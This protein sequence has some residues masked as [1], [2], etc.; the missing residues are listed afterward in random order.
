MLQRRR[1]LRGLGLG[2]HPDPAL[3]AFA[4]HLADLTGAPY[5][6][7]N[8]IDENRQFFAGLHTPGGVGLPRPVTGGEHAKPEV[9]PFLEVDNARGLRMTVHQVGLRRPR[10]Q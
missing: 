2:S 4:D 7:V 9:R 3:D 8:F 10:S 6:M 5:A 1:R